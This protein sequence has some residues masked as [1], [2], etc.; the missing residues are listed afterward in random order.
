MKYA[1]VTDRLAGLGGAKWA[2]HARARHLKARGVEIIELTIGEPDVATPDAFIAEAHRSMLAGRTGYSNGRGE[3]GLV[4]ALAARYSAR[5]GRTITPDQV[6]CLPGTQTTL[7]AVMRA[8][9]EA[10]DEVLIGDPLYATYEGIIAQTGARMVPVP[11]RPEHGFRMQAADVA[12]RITPA[13]R[14]LFLNTPH[15]PTGALLRREDLVALGEL[16]RKHDLW[17]LSDEVYEDMVF[18]GN[19]FASPLDLPDLADRVIVTCSISKS[20]AAPGFRS[21]WC[22]GPEEFCARLLPLSE[23]MLFGSQ[24]FIADMT[25]MAVSQ[26][27]PVA[28]GMVERFSRRAALIADRLDGVA[29][30]RVHQPEAGMFALVDVRATGLSGVVFAEGLL[31]AQRVAVMPGES[32]GAGLAGWLRLTLTQPDEVTAEAARRIAAHA[33]SVMGRAA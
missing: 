31:D 4:R 6:M 20:H 1:S 19:T 11:L 27:S 28:A 2:L 22:I 23:T 8:I 18:P 16:A 30:V 26:P 5:R 32:F 17:I 25:Q 14:V 15:N 10:G 12:A 21:G 29:G 24:P 13:S 7:Y 9:A 33:A 3:P